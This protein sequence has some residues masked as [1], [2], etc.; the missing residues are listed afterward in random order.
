MNI[1][2][3]KGHHS[4]EVFELT[5]RAINCDDTLLILCP[6]RIDSLDEYYE[7][8]PMGQVEFFGE[9]KGKPGFYNKSSTH[10]EKPV[11]IGLFSTGTS[12]VFPKIILYTRENLKSSND[13]IMSFF[14][15]HKFT[16]ILCYPQPY[17]IFGLSLGYALAIDRDLE[18]LYREGPY[19]SESHKQWIETVKNFGEEVLTLGTPTHMR[20]LLSFVDKESLT[21]SSSLTSI[22]G[23]ESVSVDLWE[24]A[25]AILKIQAPSIGYGCSEASPGVTHLPPGVHP[26]NNGNLGKALPGVELTS[27]DHGL[28]VC[29]KNICEAIIQNGEITFPRNE[30]LMSDIVKMDKDE[31]YQYISRCSLILNRGGEKFS[32]EMIE[33]FIR[34]SLSLNIIA[35][36]IDDER[37][38]EDLGG[39]VESS[40]PKVVS[41]IVETLKG[42][43]KRSFKES[44]FKV[45]ES[46]PKN[47]NAKIDRKG[48]INFIEELVK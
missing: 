8:L 38:G 31:N 32:L 6:P 19:S 21:P 47:S 44:N 5:Q 18:L 39:L 3:W 41:K 13:G 42:K 33:N 20:D 15:E 40:D 10:F 11:S 22:F 34:E 45:I 25:Q 23:G 4:K 48:A 29:G 7:F 16:K 36:S 27:L 26:G 43:F 14:N 24:K 17:H 37:L 28:R 30:Y 12:D 35:V 1:L 46:L 9:F 2:I